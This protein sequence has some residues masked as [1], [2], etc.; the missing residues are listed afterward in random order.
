MTHRTLPVVR[1]RKVKGAMVMVGHG[2]PLRAR[3][4]GAAQALRSPFMAPFHREEAG[5]G[6]G[7]GAVARV[8]YNDDKLHPPSGVPP[9]ATRGPVV[10]LFA[11]I[12]RVYSNT[13]LLSPPGAPAI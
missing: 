3:R 13:P 2:V 12:A 8:P 10:G 1:L 5:G 4:P 11:C 6:G 9:I 7:G